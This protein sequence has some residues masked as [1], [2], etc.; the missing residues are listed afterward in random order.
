MITFKNRA[1]K[2]IPLLLALAVVGA[3]VGIHYYSKLT[4]TMGFGVAAVPLFNP[5]LTY[6]GMYNGPLYATSEQIGDGY[7]IEKYFKN[8]DRNGVNYFIGFFA[9]EGAQNRATLHNHSGLGYMLDA[10]QKYPNR[11][12]PFF[13][14]GRG[15]DEVE[16]LVGS[17]LTAMYKATLTSSEA[18]VGTSVIQGFGELETQEWKARHNDPKVLQLVDLAKAHG[19]SVMF[20]PVASKIKDVEAIVTAYPDTTFLIHMY[21]S[22]LKESR[23]TLI[24][25]LKKYPN[26]YF[27]IDAAHIVHRVNDDMDIL[28]DYEK[29]SGFIAEFDEDYDAILASAVK[30]YK[31]LVEGAPTKV[32]W[33][34]EAGP[35]YSFEPAVYDRL[36]K[37]SRDLIGRMPTEHQEAL[38]YKNALRAFGKGVTLTTPISIVDTKTLPFCSN[39]TVDACDDSCGIKTDADLNSPVKGGC[40]E[41]CLFT[42]RCIDPPWDD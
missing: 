29:S 11:I 3:V 38:G 15:G 31:P 24:A 9:I 42:N 37:I 14:P 30:D 18:I 21:R 25:L 5:T 26:L 27:S 22:D 23:K 36:I 7:P 10:V 4:E 16:K 35:D 6:P 13:N 39:D 32:M 19:L 12:I 28:Y 33:G 17:E 1:V 41:Q 8:L 40:F 2:F 20:H 34:T